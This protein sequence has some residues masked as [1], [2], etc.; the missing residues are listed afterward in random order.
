MTNL[1]KLLQIIK[2]TLKHQHVQMEQTAI[3]Q[4]KSDKIPFS[5]FKLGESKY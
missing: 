2:M 4:L 3:L 1:M 5:H